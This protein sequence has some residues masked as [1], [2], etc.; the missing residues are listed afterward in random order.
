MALTWKDILADISGPGNALVQAIRRRGEGFPEIGAHI[1]GHESLLAGWA[2]AARTSADAVFAQNH[3]YTGAAGSAAAQLASALGRVV[4]ERAELLRLASNIVEDG[5]QLR[6]TFSDTGE[7]NDFYGASGLWSELPDDEQAQYLALREE[8]PRRVADVIAQGNALDDE[9]ATAL[10]SA[11]GLAAPSALGS[12]EGEAQSQGDGLAFTR[13]QGMVVFQTGDG[14][15]TVSVQQASGGRLVVTVNGRSQTLSAQ[16]SQDVL[17]QTQGGND[18]VSV[19]PHVA[20][21]VRFQLGDGADVIDDQAVGGSYIDAGKGDD[22]VTLGQ[23]HNTVY[24]G[25]GNNTVT[26]SKGADYI[27]GGSGNNKI[28]A[29]SGNSVLYGGTGQNTINAGAGRNTIYTGTGEATIN[30]Q[31]GQDTIYAQAGAH[32]NAGFGT[33]RTV[34]IQP[35]E[36]PDTITVQGS[37]EFQRRMQ[38]DLELLAASPD[39]QHM[40]RALGSSG[41]NLLID[42]GHLLNDGKVL[43][44]NGYTAPAVGDQPTNSSDFFYDMERHRPGPGTDAIISIDTTLT[45]LGALA[46]GPKPDYHEL[47]PAVVLYHEMA[48]AYDDT[49]GSMMPGEYGPSGTDPIDSQNIGGW[50]PQYLANAE[51]EAVGLPLDWDGDPKTPEV[52]VPDSVHPHDL[53]ENAL[54]DEMGIPDREHYLG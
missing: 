39:G 42:D 41:H 19:D 53:T 37:P 2:G 8:L 27:N 38:D 48:H 54:R 21:R 9:A 6:F 34:T 43:Y 23:G 32:V 25:S 13:D 3:A 1:R 36:I 7:I 33:N 49:H 44:N 46:Q 35:L 18:R 11:G 20:V 30:N 50:N 16:D 45:N 15:D 17:I 40:L 10:T 52:A 26:G 31:G 29:G 47:N 51:H 22:T 12:G 4:D 24:L 5:A 28:N 14:D